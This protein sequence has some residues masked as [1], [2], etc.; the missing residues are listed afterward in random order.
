MGEEVGGEPIGLAESREYA[1]LYVL[2]PKIFVDP[3]V[4]EDGIKA[5]NKSRSKREINE[6]SR[7]FFVQVKD[8]SKID[9]CVAERAKETLVKATIISPQGSMNVEARNSGNALG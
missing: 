3:K 1:V 7:S 2:D 9:Y 8:D 4:L 6:F 5:N